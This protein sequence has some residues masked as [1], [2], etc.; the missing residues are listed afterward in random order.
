[1]I[2]ED[3]IEIAK[4]KLETNAQK[5][6]KEQIERYYQIKE[7]EL[8]NNNYQIGDIV[9]LSKGTLLHG[10]YKNID[11]LKEILKDGLISSRFIDCRISK[12]PSSVGV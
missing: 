5:I 4:N 6:M 8:P 3:Y 7:L 11:G 9:K 1:M 12:Y 10:T 2:K